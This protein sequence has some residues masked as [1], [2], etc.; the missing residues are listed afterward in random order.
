MP[1]RSGRPVPRQPGTADAVGLPSSF[2]PASFL[3]LLVLALLR[4]V[5]SCRVSRAHAPNWRP[6]P[7]IRTA[8][9]IAAPYYAPRRHRDIVRQ[10]IGDP[11][12]RPRAGHYLI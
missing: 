9:L 7:E 12:A 8:N 10:H 2:L 5:I 11:A 4:S 1:S 6:K 3:A